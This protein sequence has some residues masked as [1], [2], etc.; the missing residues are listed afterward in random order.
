MPRSPLDFY[1]TP[2]GVTRAILSALRLVNMTGLRVVDPSAGDGAILDVCLER[3]ATTLG[4]ELD[5]DRAA[6]CNEKGHKVHVGDAL[7]RDY[8]ADVDLIIQN[9]PFNQALEHVQK[10]AVWADK[11]QRRAI[12]LVRSGFLSSKARAPFH[13]AYPGDA[14][15]LA[16]RPSFTG[17]GKTDASDYVILVHGKGHTGRWQVLDWA[18]R[19][20]GVQPAAPPPPRKPRRLKQQPL[21][22][23]TPAAVAAE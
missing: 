8:P 18:P 7:S 2:P 9:C 11:H 22:D 19:V 4:I 14:Y 1:C 16:G 13:K 17:D 20:R 6:L 10:A 15:F 12:S 21:L 3:G 5:A 23:V